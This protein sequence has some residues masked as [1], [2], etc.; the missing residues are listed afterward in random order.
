MSKETDGHTPVETGRKKRGPVRPVL[1][2]VRL[3]LSTFI[4]ISTVLNVA[5]KARGVD[6]LVFPVPLGALLIRWGAY[7]NARWYRPLGITWMVSG[8]LMAF[9]IPSMS[10]AAPRFEG[11]SYRLLAGVIFMVVVGA[12]FL[13]SREKPRA[14]KISAIGQAQVGTS[15]DSQGT[16]QIRNS[17]GH[18][19][20]SPLLVSA[21]PNLE[22]IFTGD[23]T[24]AIQML[25]DGNREYWS[26]A[27]LRERRMTALIGYLQHPDAPVRMATMRFVASNQSARVS[28]VLFDRFVSDPDVAV[29]VSAAKTIWECE[30]DSN[31]KFAIGKLKDTRDQ[32]R[33]QRALRLLID[34][35]PSDESRQAVQRLFS[36]DVDD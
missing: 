3:V 20:G 23:N 6:D 28:Q 1:S 4:A 22:E 16:I 14:A 32:S 15:H 34:S 5:M 12:L 29:Q 7:G 31:C 19:D 2:L 21:S 35:A 18:Y 26:T 30:K 33:V 8:I 13:F 10:R 11:L 24:P 9:A 17:Y 36:T 27:S 25:S